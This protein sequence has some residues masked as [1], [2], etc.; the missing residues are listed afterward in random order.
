MPTE[1]GASEALEKIAFPDA[2]DRRAGLR[3]QTG[4]GRGRHRLGCIQNDCHVSCAQF[5]FQEE[6][7]ASE[8]C[9]HLAPNLHRYPPSDI[10]R[11][12]QLCVATRPPSF[13]LPSSGSYSL[14]QDMQ[15][16]AVRPGGGVLPPQV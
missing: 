12:D 15:V 2:S 1:S 5:M 9:S 11:A 16:H 8:Y 7:E 3:N 13:S 4:G 10:L 14:F 6:E